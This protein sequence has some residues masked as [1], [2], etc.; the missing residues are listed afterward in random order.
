[1]RLF[2]CQVRL[3][4]EKNLIKTERLLSYNL[5]QLQEM[6]D[7]KMLKCFQK[8]ATPGKAYKIFRGQKKSR[9][10]G[11]IIEYDGKKQ[12]DVWPTKECNKLGGTDGTIFPPFLKKEEGL[13]SYSSDLCRCFFFV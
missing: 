1:M 3:C 11:L 4:Y 12:M 7:L 8:N 5:N 6:S 10:L 9:N 2:N 13:E